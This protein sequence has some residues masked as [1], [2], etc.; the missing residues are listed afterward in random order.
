M[1]VKS[2]KVV[3]PVSCFLGL[4]VN[5]FL[6]HFCLLHLFTIGP[7]SILK[8]F[9]VFL[10]KKSIIY[11]ICRYFP[12]GQPAYCI[13]NGGNS[14]FSPVILSVSSPPT[15]HSYREQAFSH[16]KNA[17]HFLVASFLG[18]TQDSLKKSSILQKSVTGHFPKKLGKIFD[19]CK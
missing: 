18:F 15:D 14:H 7:N 2:F 13:Y 8:K 1:S 16:K 17:G 12:A 3:L 9:V 10:E 5:I 11:H 6:K 19:G 4:P